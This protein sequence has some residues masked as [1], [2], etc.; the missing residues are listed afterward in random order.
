M[1]SH[2][3]YVEHKIG[4][5][6]VEYEYDVEFEYEPYVPAQ[7][8]GPPD[9]CYPAEGGY[10]EDFEGPIRRRLTDNKEAKWETVPFSI[11]LEGVIESRSFVDDPADKKYRKTAKEKAMQYIESELSEAGEEAMRDA[12]DAAQEAK[13][14]YYKDEGLL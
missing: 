5:E 11:F 14:D 7:I 4:E 10:A 12:Y 13:Y 9:R 3:F 8:S 2:S 6:Y 1:G